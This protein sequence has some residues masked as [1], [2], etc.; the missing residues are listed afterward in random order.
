V[1][2]KA[3]FAFLAF[4][5]AGRDLHT[6]SLGTVLVHGSLWSL[7]PASFPREHS[8][9]PEAEPLF[10]AHCLRVSATTAC[11]ELVRP[12]YSLPR[13]SLRSSDPMRTTDFCFPLP[14]NEYPRLVELPASLRGFRLALDPRLCGRSQET[15]GLGV[16]RRRVRFGGLG[17]V[18]VRSV[19]PALSIEPYL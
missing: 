18:G 8:T 10:S 2:D 17:R 5:R 4:D 6:V 14:F 12:S 16:S 13:G 3:E 1:P 7:P 19:S 15:G 11:L 9:P